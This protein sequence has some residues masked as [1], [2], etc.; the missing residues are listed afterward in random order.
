MLQ[1]ILTTSNR[2]SI[3]EQAQMAVEGGARWLELSLPDAEDSFIRDC[4]AEIIP[5]CEETGSFLTI[6]N[7]PQ[8][9]RQMNI[10]GVHLDG[11]ESPGAVR[12]ELGAEAIIGV[13][14]S[15][16]TAASSIA[17][18]DADYIALPSGTEPAQ[19]AEYVTAVRGMGVELPI[20]YTAIG[21]ELPEN[22]M[23]TGVS[24]VATDCI[25]AA[26]DPVK[27]CSDLLNSLSAR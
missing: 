17:A 13:T 15:A 18:M 6:R 19:V 10:H 2:F 5:L 11:T 9:A 22:I 21:T 26:H 1:V 16:P 20:V 7:H 23:S 25:F 4:L 3:P 14:S 12:E 24:G 27:A 8:M